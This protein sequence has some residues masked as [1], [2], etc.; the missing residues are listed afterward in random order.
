VGRELL[1]LLEG[2]RSSPSG[3]RTTSGSRIGAT[4]NQKYS[5]LRGRRERMSLAPRFRPTPA[6]YAVR[7]GRADGR[8]LR[9]APHPFSGVRRRGAGLCR[10]GRG[11]TL[12]LHD[13]SRR[14]YR[15]PA[16]QW[17]ARPR[18]RAGGRGSRDAVG[19]PLG[20]PPGGS[21][22]R[23]AA[24]WKLEGGRGGR[25]FSEESNILPSVVP[26]R[27]GDADGWRDL[28]W[29]CRSPLKQFPRRAGGDSRSAA[30][31]RRDA[32]GTGG[33]ARSRA[34]RRRR[35]MLLGVGLPLE[36]ELGGIP[37]AA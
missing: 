3:L 10:S 27:I 15:R 5:E 21:R 20:H 16:S 8:P 6:R 14:E 29:P 24:T 18:R 22:S 37:G 13:I 30:G 7:R 35:P 19:S 9:P 26:A 1:G 12:F 33:T 31:A 4:W 32:G 17:F 23:T 11:A 2:Q 25:G 36:G 28:G 34:A